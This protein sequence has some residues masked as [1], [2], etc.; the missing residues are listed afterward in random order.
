[1]VEKS[2]FFNKYIESEQN[3]Y[4]ESIIKKLKSLKMDGSQ[5]F[6]LMTKIKTES[7]N[8]TILVRAQ[9]V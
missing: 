7:A 1:M 4:N 3:I 8:G 5:N 6:K 2:E 9:T